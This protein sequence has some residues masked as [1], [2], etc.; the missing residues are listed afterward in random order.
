[1]NDTERREVPSYPNYYVDYHGNVYHNNVRLSISS[2][3][4]S[5]GYVNI[6]QV[7]KLGKWYNK[8]VTVARM[9]GEAWLGAGPNDFI[10]FCDG[11]NTNLELSN[12]YIGTRSDFTKQLYEFRKENN[13]NADRRL[14]IRNMYD[15]VPIYQLDCETYLIVNRF[16]SI[17]DAANTYDVPVNNIGRCCFDS[18]KTC[19]NHK[20]CFQNEYDNFV[21]SMMG[22]DTSGN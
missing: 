4:G 5:Y 11:D 14:Q 7:S 17:K 2:H 1:M 13:P 6:K 15:C 19:L 10:C 18:T 21:S 22:G 20:W 8:K 3:N 12:L 16:D 9:M